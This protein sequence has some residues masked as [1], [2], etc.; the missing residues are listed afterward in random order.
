MSSR[1][2]KPC[3]APSA[4]QSDG[5]GVTQ[6]VVSW[7]SLWLL[8]TWVWLL[9]SGISQAN[10][11][12]P[13]Q[14]HLQLAAASDLRDALTA[15]SNQF[16]QL[17]PDATVD[18]IFGSSGKLSQQIQHGAPFDLYFAADRSYTDGL[19]QQGLNLNTAIVIGLGRLVLVTKP[20]LPLPQALEPMTSPTFS[21]IAIAEPQHAPYGE[22]AKQALQQQQLCSR[23]EH[24]LVYADNV[25]KALQLVQTGA[26][27]AAI[28]ALALVKKPAIV[29]AI[30]PAIHQ[31]NHPP[32][33]QAYLEIAENLHQP[34]QATM[35]VIKQPTRP[36][37]LTK[38]ALRFYAYVQSEPA[39]QLLRQYGFAQPTATVNHE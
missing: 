31:H 12:V 26:V 7:R 24:K 9:L 39:Q 18:I 3:A 21:R 11:F 2:S 37:D 32:P 8:I 27:D 1:F 33:H 34:L 38:Q 17:Y 25:A 36:A 28:V 20:G 35:M 13:E 15:I 23:I 10:E 6:Q 29:S 19:V 14:R 16:R 5:H 30:V 22:R 4:D